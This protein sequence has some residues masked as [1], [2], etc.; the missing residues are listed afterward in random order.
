MAESGHLVPPLAPCE[1]YRE[2]GYWE[3]AAKAGFGQHWFRV[4]A[5]LVAWDVRANW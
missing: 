3:A 4:D 1:T 2:Q 5:P